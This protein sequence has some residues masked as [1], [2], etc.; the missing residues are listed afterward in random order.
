MSTAKLESE[1]HRVLKLTLDATRQFRD[2]IS[3]T[4]PELAAVWDH[5]VREAIA[6]VERL[7]LL[8]LKVYALPPEQGAKARQEF[9]DYAARAF[10]AN[11][12]KHMAEL[13]AKVEARHPEP[14]APGDSKSR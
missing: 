4:E 8:L 7:G 6:P 13:E 11:W 12:R 14:P 5:H 10:G 2:R 9:V 1:L 3:A